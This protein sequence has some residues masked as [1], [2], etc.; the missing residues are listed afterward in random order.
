MRHSIFVTF[1]CVNIPCEEPLQRG[2][3]TANREDILSVIDFV[4]QT[5]SWMKC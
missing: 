3:K 5:C 1:P 4:L 2:F